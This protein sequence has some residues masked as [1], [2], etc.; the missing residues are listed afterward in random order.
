V[1]RK[2]VTG[3][4]EPA[5]PGLPLVLAPFGDCGALLE[6]EVPFPKTVIDELEGPELL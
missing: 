1:S 4:F 6:D 3:T 2:L 5:E